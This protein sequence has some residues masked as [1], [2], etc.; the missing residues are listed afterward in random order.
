MDK[1]TFTREELYDLV[2]SEPMLS[3]SKKYNISDVGLRKTC[4]RMS[5]PMPKAGHWQKLKFG[6]KIKKVPLPG[7]YQGEQKVSFSLRDEKTPFPVRGESPLSVLKHQIE[8]DNLLKLTVPDKLTNPDKLIIAAR[9]SLNRKDSHAHHGLI[10]C[11]RGELD[12][13]VTKENVPRAL[14]FMDVFI[15]A[16]RTRGHEITIENDSTHAVVKT[17]KLEISLREKTKRIPGT[18]RWQ[19]SD[20]QPTGQLVFKLDKTFYDRDW[21]DGKL[22]LEDQFPTIL[23]KLELISVELNE[24]ELVWQKQRAERE[25][26]EKLRKAFEEKQQKD[27]ADF[28]D[29]LLK[30]ARWH[31]AVNLRNYINTFEQNAISSNNLSEELKEWLA[32]ARK[33]ADW[34]DPFI[35]LQDELLNEVDRETLTMAKKD[36]FFGW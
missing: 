19:T 9:E 13:R 14:R 28:K 36:S 27:L 35:E 16:M 12:I 5:I 2:W 26:Q 24:R 8:N 3:L 11:Q 34:Y 31:K 20:Y 25:R 29:M 17:Q 10:S 7:N 23:A 21:V 22:P 33:K 6:K 30:A 18:D 15:K 1:Q 4:I 32:W